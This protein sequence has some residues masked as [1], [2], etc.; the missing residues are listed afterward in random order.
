MTIQNLPTPSTDYDRQVRREHLS[1][2][3]AVQRQWAQ[4]GSDFDA[5]WAALAPEIAAI[6]RVAQFK[7]VERSA[8][9]IPAVLTALGI[10]AAPQVPAVVNTTEFPGFTAGG[11]ALETVLALAPIRAKQAVQ[12]TWVPGHVDEA[13]GVYLPT[14]YM[15]GLSVP[16]ALTVAG[17]WLTRA[18]GTVLSDTAREAE[19]VGVTMSKAA[20]WVRMLTPP[21]CSR[22]VL[23]AGKFFRWNEGFLRHPGCDCKHIPA[24]ES[25]AGDL[26][27]NPYAYFHS[28]DRA[29]QDKTFTKA[30][31]EAIRDGADI[32]QVV[33][34]RRGM[35]KTGVFTY[36]GTT[37][38]GNA[39]KRL[40]P[41]QRRMTPQSIYD[42]AER[43]ADPGKEREFALDLLEYHGYILPGGQNPT[44]SLRGQREGWGQLGSGG[45]IGRSASDRARVNARKA[46]EEARR[47][48]VRDPNVRYTMT[49]AERRVHDAKTKYEIALSGRSPY[50]SEPAFRNKPDPSGSLLYVGNGRGSNSQF[51]PVTQE[52]LATARR[53]YLMWLAAR[54]QIFSD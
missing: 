31:A 24:S 51:V 50:R 52:E 2:I 48:G 46:I 36:E 21:S 25:I 8:D 30:G 15:P 11:V 37:G 6:L 22:C 13:S 39:A 16:D 40:K 9:Y 28:L 42:Q 47:S 38:Q 27:V 3:A 43:F 26:T 49:A 32:F 18:V 45:G 44:G 5:S 10:A 20:G 35:T 12:G 29:E 1:A 41:R 19:S 4:M 7:I 14:S 53:T 23:Q 34:A 33:N 54:G 17:R